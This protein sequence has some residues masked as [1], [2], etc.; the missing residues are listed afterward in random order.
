MKILLK[1]FGTL[2]T[3]IGFIVIIISGL[4]SIYLVFKVAF[5]IGG[6]L[7]ILIGV[8]VGPVLFFAAPIYAWFQWGDL[9]IVIIEYGGLLLGL[10]LTGIG[11]ILSGE[12]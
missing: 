1:I 3:G 5:I 7:G 12:Y 10:V 8:A 6:P 11:S 9:S 2:I 4:W